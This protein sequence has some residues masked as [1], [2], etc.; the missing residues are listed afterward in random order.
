MGKELET[1]H[2]DP[3][4]LRNATSIPLRVND[5]L[6]DQSLESEIPFSQFCEMKSSPGIQ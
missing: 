1:G 5:R 6:F 4:S 3:I 2:M